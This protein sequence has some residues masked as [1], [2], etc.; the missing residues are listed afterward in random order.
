[1]LRKGLALALARQGWEVTGEAGTGKDAVAGVCRTNPDLAI[2]GVEMR[3]MNG[4]EALREIKSRR[5]SV[6]VLIYTG[7]PVFEYLTRAVDSGAAGFLLKD[8]PE[9]VLVSEIRRIAMGE[10]VLG[11]EWLI[12]ILR[13]I[14]AKSWEKDPKGDGHPL[15]PRELEILQAIGKGLATEEIAAMFALSVC[16]VNVHVHNFL[17]KL[18]VSDRTQALVW[19]ARR[20]LITFD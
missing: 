17:K 9:E 10:Q 3:E 6:A 13:E 7:R 1:M 18:R 14:Q 12:S 19:A 20:K 16:T 8:A 15:S 4:L 2:L 11:T 5:P